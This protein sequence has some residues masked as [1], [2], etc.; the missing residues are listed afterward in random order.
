MS[1]STKQ[2]P[3]RILTVTTGGTVTLPNGIIASIDPN[4]DSVT[5]YLIEGSATLSSNLIYTMTTPV[6][7]THIDIF[8]K[9][10]VTP[11]GNTLTILGKVIPSR[12]L[13]KTFILK[14]VYDGSA[15]ETYLF[16]DNDETSNIDGDSI[17]DNSIDNVKIVDVAASKLTGTVSDSQ[18]AAMNA[19]KLSGS[20]DPARY[21]NNT[22]PAA[23]MVNS[24]L[25][26]A[27]MA[28]GAITA[29]KLA[30]TGTLHMNTTG[31]STTAVVTEEILGTYALPAN[32]IASTN[33][34]IRVKGAFT[35]AANANTKTVRLK[36]NGQTIYSSATAVPTDT[37]PNNGR[38]YF[39]FDLIRTGAT[40]AKVMGMSHI[41]T[42]TTDSAP[43][44]GNATGLDF[45]AS[46]NIEW[47][48]QNG[49]ASSSDIV[50]ESGSVE[51][52]L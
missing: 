9:A 51:I 1:I 16:V 17:V 20:I 12:L 50:F 34:G 23:A 10:A 6:K 19:N 21:A 5:E 11:S 40:T 36:I 37:A 46:Q 48:G 35:F 43:G 14:A 33:K 2:K 13:S 15:W 39:E 47:T 45:T 41:S 28:D 52:I 31:G 3:Y 44:I 18:I 32:T 26:A 25:T 29:S 4:I 42:T 22:I 8:Y 27:Q 24:S 49:T 30:S 7:G 38:L